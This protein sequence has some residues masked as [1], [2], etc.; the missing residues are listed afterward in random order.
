ADQ[1]L[2]AR[3]LDIFEHSM[4]FGDALV[5]YPELVNEIGEPVQLESGR[6]EDGAALRRFYRR[7]MFRIQCASMHDAEPIFD[8][9][10]KTS[11]LADLVIATAYRL[12]VDDARPES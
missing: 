5:R 2:A 4:Y 6:L 9:L 7:Q 12:A 3:V 11:A 10:A 8:T 1:K